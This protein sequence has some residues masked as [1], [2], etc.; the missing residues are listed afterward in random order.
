MYHKVTKN[1]RALNEFTY[2][3][4][5][6]CPSLGA[7]VTSYVEY[8]SGHNLEFAQIYDDPILN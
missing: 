1:V 3:L 2:K 5:I 4:M 6:N 8:V 7:I